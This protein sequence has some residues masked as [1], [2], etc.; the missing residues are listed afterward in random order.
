MAPV[1]P[2]K[3]FFSCSS[4]NEVVIGEAVNDAVL[5]GWSCHSDF[6]A[7]PLE[8]SLRGLIKTTLLHGSGSGSGQQP[9]LRKN[10]P[11]LPFHGVSRGHEW[12]AWPALSCQPKIFRRITS[13]AAASSSSSSRKVRSKA[14]R[15]DIAA[16]SDFAIRMQQE[17]EKLRINALGN[18]INGGVDLMSRINE[19]EDLDLSL[20][21]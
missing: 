18:I 4:K 21:L 17:R 1:M 13:R 10:A 2:K 6:P 9:L 8:P 15:F 20:S 11:P 5:A 12:S 14:P 16:A 7:A 3:S 19:Y